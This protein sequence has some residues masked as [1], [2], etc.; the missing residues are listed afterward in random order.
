MVG[1]NLRFCW[2]YSTKNKMAIVDIAPAP[3]AVAIISIIYLKNLRI[4]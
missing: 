2:R 4:T 3:Y 1:E